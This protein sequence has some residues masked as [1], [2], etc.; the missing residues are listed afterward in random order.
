MSPSTV[1]VPVLAIRMASNCWV[2]ALNIAVAHGLLH[3]VGRCA[4]V[5]FLWKTV[6]CGSLHTC[7]V[8]QA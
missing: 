7:F 2:P 4:V 3:I 5:L 8:L 6:A 1:L